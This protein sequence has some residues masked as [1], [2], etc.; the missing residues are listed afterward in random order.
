MSTIQRLGS[1]TEF[2]NQI[3]DLL[4]QESKNFD[5]VENPTTN[6]QQATAE[7][8]EKSTTVFQGIVEKEKVPFQDLKFQRDSIEK[9][10]QD[11]AAT[12][13]LEKKMK[14]SKEV[15]TS[16]AVKRNYSEISNCSDDEKTTEFER[17]KELGKQAYKRKE[18]EKAIEAYS[19]ASQLNSD[20][21]EVNCSYALSCFH[22]GDNEKE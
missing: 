5:E 21:F 16:S 19:K 13:D 4:N 14:E 18:W 22:S 2:K 1:P 12:N 3:V 17:Y 15:E 7:T 9:L 8:S 20:D 11:Y 6:S 10:F